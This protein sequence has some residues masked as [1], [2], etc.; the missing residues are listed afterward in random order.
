MSATSSSLKSV[1]A[2]AVLSVVGL[3][4]AEPAFAATCT[5]SLPGGDVVYTLNTATNAFCSTGNDL[6]TI[7]SS[8]TL[9][10]QTGWI[11]G[12]STGGVGDNAV[13]FTQNG[14]PVSGAQSGTWAITGLANSIVVVLKQANS[15]AA[16]LVSSTSGTWSVTGPGDSVNVISHASVY[17]NGSVI[18]LP[19]A[20]LLF[21][22]ALAGVGA[23]SRKRRKSA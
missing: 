3:F 21:G 4:A 12:D 16:F 14:A 20:A 6:N 17:Y 22:T 7:D 8:Y 5:Q 15:F 1:A 13:K 23:M 18:P 10:G 19:P 2:A 11:L 9:F